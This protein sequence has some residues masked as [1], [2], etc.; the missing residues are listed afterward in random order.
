MGLEMEGGERAKSRFPWSLLH[1]KSPLDV[2]RIK[3]RS[4]IATSEV[5]LGFSIQLRY[6]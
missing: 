2:G 5:L 6:S 3:L 4:T 1:Y